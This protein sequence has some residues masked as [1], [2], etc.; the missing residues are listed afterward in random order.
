M[1]NV[2]VDLQVMTAALNYRHMHELSLDPS[3]ATKANDGHEHQA[4]EGETR[5]DG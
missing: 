3:K 4:P 1:K 5:E 2:L